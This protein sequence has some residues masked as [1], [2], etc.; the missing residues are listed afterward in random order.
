MQTVGMEIGR[1]VG[2]HIYQKSSLEVFLFKK[3]EKRIKKQNNKKRILK[4]KTEQMKEKQ[5][6]HIKSNEIDIQ[7][8]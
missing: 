7:E 4:E 2:S 8:N 3:K 1:R 6:N 5:I